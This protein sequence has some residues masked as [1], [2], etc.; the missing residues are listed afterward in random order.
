MCRFMLMVMDIKSTMDLKQRTFTSWKKRNNRKP[1]YI[2]LP[3]ITY[4]QKQLHMTN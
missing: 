1:K 3:P 2:K 4:I